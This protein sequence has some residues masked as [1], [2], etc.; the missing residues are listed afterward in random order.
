[1]LVLRIIMNLQMH[2]QEFSVSSELLL[3]SV[4]ISACQGCV[5]LCFPC[6]GKKKK[7]FRPSYTR[8]SNHFMASGLASPIMQ[9]CHYELTSV[10]PSLYAGSNKPKHFLSNIASFKHPLQC[11]LQKR[12]ILHAYKRLSGSCSLHQCMFAS[13][14]SSSGYRKCLEL[15]QIN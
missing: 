7:I 3:F 2:F 1:M 12:I 5:H 10:R 6:N 4:F 8:Q 15:R 11:G 9:K 14:T 13:P